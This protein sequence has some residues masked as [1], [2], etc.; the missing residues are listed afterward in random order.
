MTDQESHASGA[1]TVSVV[2]PT[3]NRS[4]VLPRAVAS[5][6]G[7]TFGDLE[8]IVV[9]DGSTDGTESAVMATGDPRVR[10]VRLA[11]RG[12]APAARNVGIA[13]ARGRYIAFQDSDDEWDR[14]KLVRQLEVMR[15]LDESW[16]GVYTALERRDDGRVTVVPGQEHGPVL[17]GDVLEALLPGNFISTQTALIRADQLGGET[18]FDERLP[19]LQDWDLWLTLATKGRFAFLPAVLVRQHLSDDSITRDAQAYFDALE[20]ILAKHRKSFRRRP[21]VIAG[22]QF[23]LAVSAARARRYQRSLH[24]LLQGLRVGPATASR[25]YLSRLV[26]ATQRRG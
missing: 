11:H 3:Y 14:S 18:A 6:L 22:H 25:T 9:D 1:P 12:G 10:L 2:L 5:V 16:V 23:T 4:A 20:L 7:Q 19:R 17:S 15:G 24:H 13:L 26:Q 8:L 21:D